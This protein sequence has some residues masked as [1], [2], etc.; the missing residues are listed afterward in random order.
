MEMYMY[1]G[2]SD[3]P[4]RTVIGATNAEALPSTHNVAATVENFMVSGYCFRQR[5]RAC[6]L[7]MHSDS[8]DSMREK[9]GGD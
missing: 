8:L 6:V 3:S 5:E 1:S 4:D 2:N 9:G 7:M